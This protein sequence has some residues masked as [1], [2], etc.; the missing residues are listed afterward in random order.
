MR[1]VFFLFI[2]LCITSGLSGQSKQDDF[3]YFV[4]DIL[5]TELADSISD[6]LKTKNCRAIILL[7][8]TV[9]KYKDKAD[10]VCILTEE[11]IFLEDPQYYFEFKKISINGKRSLVSF[12]IIHRN[13]FK[14][15][16]IRKIDLLYEKV[17]HKWRKR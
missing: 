17:N 16:E 11:E 14:K 6:E 9:S 3:N 7:N 4:Q 12:G 8:N 1:W 13:P 10:Q 5:A 2:C 15:V